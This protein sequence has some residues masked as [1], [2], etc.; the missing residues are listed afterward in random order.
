MCTPV[1]RCQVDQTAMPANL[2]P[3]HSFFAVEG[4][5]ILETLKPAEDGDG[6]I[7]RLYEPY[8]GRGRVRVRVTG[9]LGTVNEC[10]HVEEP[11]ADV[12]AEASSFGFAITP[13]QVRTF[14]VHL[15]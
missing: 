15:A 8:G 5:A 11:L 4:P 7:L 2:P 14:R 10:N 13:Y 3:A 1:S 12:V 9:R 6:L